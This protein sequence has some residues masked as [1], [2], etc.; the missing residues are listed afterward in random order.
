MQQAW[1]RPCAHGSRTAMERAARAPSMAMAAFITTP[2]RAAP[3]MA[4][5]TCTRVHTIDSHRL[6]GSSGVR[7]G[8]PSYFLG[9]PAR[10]RAGVRR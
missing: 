8:V 10:V 2:Q 4:T 9:A 6:H 5:A 1:R 3:A 7:E